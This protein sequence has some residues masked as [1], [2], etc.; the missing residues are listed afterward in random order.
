MALGRV[1]SSKAGG[2]ALRDEE[3]LKKIMAELHLGAQRVIID[4]TKFSTIASANLSAVV[5][6]VSV[7]FA[8]GPLACFA[9]GF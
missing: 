3:R 4:R 7:L 9:G 5:R 6:T 2:L 8:T 1:L